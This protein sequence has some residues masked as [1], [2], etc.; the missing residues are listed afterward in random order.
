MH[1]YANRVLALHRPD[2]CKDDHQNTKL[3]A[4]AIQL[5]LE[6]ALLYPNNYVDKVSNLHF[7]M[8]NNLKKY[9]HSPKG[10]IKS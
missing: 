7:S 2:H 6:V 3:D 1:L 10:V 9:A 4:Q 8:Y 5:I